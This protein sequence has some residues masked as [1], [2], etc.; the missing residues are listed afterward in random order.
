MSPPL[1]DLPAAKDVDRAEVLPLRAPSL[2]CSVAV[3]FDF[4]R[5]EQA[6]PT[7]ITRFI[8]WGDVTM[9]LYAYTLPAQASSLAWIIEG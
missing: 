5:P 4:V 9:R 8:H 1:R 6:I 3:Y 2:D 7:D